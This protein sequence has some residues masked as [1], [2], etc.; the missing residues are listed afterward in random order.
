MRVKIKK[1]R[2]KT[3]NLNK[4]VGSSQMNRL[5]RRKL[6]KRSK[7]NQILQ[8]ENLSREG[9]KNIQVLKINNLINIMLS[10]HYLNKLSNNLMEKKANSIMSRILRKIKIILVVNNKQPYNK[11]KTNQLSKIMCRRNLNRWTVMKKSFKKSETG[12]Y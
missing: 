1:P 3:N 9:V 7:Y 4:P 5:A 6:I 8:K 10:K 2:L 12:N 11:I